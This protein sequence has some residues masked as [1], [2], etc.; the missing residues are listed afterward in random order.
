MKEANKIPRTEMED[1]PGENFCSLRWPIFLRFELFLRFVFFLNL[2]TK[3]YRRD[4][5]KWV[6]Q[7]VFCLFFQWRFL[8]DVGFR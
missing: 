3:I 2:E 5:E 1:G 7:A 4:P 6:C 8:V